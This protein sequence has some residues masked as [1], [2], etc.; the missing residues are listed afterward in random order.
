VNFGDWRIAPLQRRILLL[1]AGA[2]LS[3][4]ALA[5][6]STAPAN[7]PGAGPGG[8]DI[9]FASTVGPL[10]AGKLCFP[11][12]KLRVRDFVSG[13]SAF[14][15]MVTEAVDGLESNRKA[16]LLA[17]KTPVSIHLTEIKA[18]L[19]ARDWGAFGYGDRRSLAGEAAFTF[20]LGTV[21]QGSPVVTKH[22]VA[23]KL[24]GAEALPPPEILQAALVQ[25]LNT[26]AA[27]SGQ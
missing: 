7:L 6:E 4:P 25:L 15:V 24:K 11:N 22:E 12:G 14:G 19:C 5:L 20:E 8:V 13:Q 3:C 17:S 16:R 10:R 18:K 26:V 1:L 27:E 2:L 23:L 9:P 21:R